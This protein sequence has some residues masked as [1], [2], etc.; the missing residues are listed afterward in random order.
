MAKS[1][2]LLASLACLLL[3]LAPAAQAQEGSIRAAI[4]NQLEAFGRDDGTAA[5][6]Y[7]SPGIRAR[8]GSADRFMAMVRDGYPAVYRPLEVEFRALTLQDD[9][10]IQEVY[11]IGPDGGAALGLYLI[12]RQ[13]DGS[14]LI[15]GVRLVELP[16][17][18]S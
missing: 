7:A 11:F 14:W 15:D 17:T 8:F 2:A 13:P 16:E 3:L 10:G 4:G 18:V 6:A 9:R 5:F 1:R 12:E